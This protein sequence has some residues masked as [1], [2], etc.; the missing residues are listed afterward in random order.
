MKLAPLRLPDGVAV[1]LGLTSCQARNIGE[2]TD[3]AVGTTKLPGKILMPSV[4]VFLSVVVEHPEQVAQRL[5]RHAN[6][7]GRKNVIACADCGFGNI[8]EQSEVHAAVPWVKID[9]LVEGV[10][11]ASKMLWR[12]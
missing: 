11:R 5:I 2:E 4:V 12:H 10:L 8:A 1:A 6:L 7:V 3:D 9:A